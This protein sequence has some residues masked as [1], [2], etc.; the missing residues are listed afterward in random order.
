M[1]KKITLPQLKKMVRESS[2]PVEFSLFARDEAHRL[3]S[4]LFSTATLQVIAR[5]LEDLEKEKLKA[6]FK[7]FAGHINYAYCIWEDEE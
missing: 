5:N 4:T 1:E 3:N 6:A 2:E 7:K